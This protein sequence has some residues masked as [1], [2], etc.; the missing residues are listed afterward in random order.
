MEAPRRLMVCDDSEGR[1]R[2]RLRVLLDG[3][4]LRDVIAYDC[5]AGWIVVLKHD[6]SG[7]RMTEGDCFI[8]ERRHGKVT[9]VLV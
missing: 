8:A 5:D 7:N 2:P 3:D 4:S 1:L 6:D 9:A